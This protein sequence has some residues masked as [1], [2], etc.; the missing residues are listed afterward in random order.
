[1]ANTKV[2]LHI[3]KKLSL[4]ISN[5]IKTIICYLAQVLHTCTRPNLSQMILHRVQTI[6]LQAP[7]IAQTLMNIVK[8]AKM[9]FLMLLF[10]F[11]VLSNTLTSSLNAPPH[12]YTMG[13]AHLAWRPPG[14]RAQ[15]SS[16]S[17]LHNAR[18]F[19]VNVGSTNMKTILNIISTRRLKTSDYIITTLTWLWQ[20]PACSSPRTP[21]ISC[22][23]S[24]GTHS[25]W[26][27]K[28][29]HTLDTGSYKRFKKASD[30]VNIFITIIY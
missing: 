3:T 28:K 9:K 30:G 4:I 21:V 29:W 25:F 15:R 8:I 11:P 20:C 13:T 6:H 1:M 19:M 16:Q 7:T 26:S 17:T 12:G 2:S 24:Y 23:M 5:L 10:S 22:K 18:H 14:W 27:H